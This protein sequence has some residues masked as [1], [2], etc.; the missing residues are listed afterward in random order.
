MKR[1]IKMAA[2]GALALAL[3]ACGGAKQENGVKKIEA[4]K[5]KELMDAGGVTVVDVRT[6]EEYA[7]AHVPGAVLVPLDTIGGKAPAE[8]PDKEAKLLVYCRSGRRSAQAAEQLAALG[9]SDV[10]DFGGILDWPYETE[11]G[12][13]Q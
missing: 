6:A 5:A 2:A 3:A 12:A 1:W 7:E 13:A 8:L 4:Q 10:Y 11:T 9:Y